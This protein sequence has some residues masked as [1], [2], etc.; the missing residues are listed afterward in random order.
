MLLALAI[1]APARADLWEESLPMGPGGLVEVE[2]DLGEGL[3]PDPGSLTIRSHSRDEVRMEI[4]SGGWGTWGLAPRLVE[5]AGRVRAEARVTGATTWMFG[6]PNVRVRLWV[7]EKTSLEVRAKG[8]PVRIEELVGSVRARVR[9]GDLEIRSIEGDVKLRLHQANV[10]VEEIHGG[11]DV[12]STDGDIHAAWV[13][14]D[15]E[16]RSSDGAIRLE[17]LRGRALAKTLS[18]DV[19]VTQVSGP[20]EARTESGQLRVSFVGAP[21]G[22]LLVERGNVEVQVPAGAG[23]HLDAEVT[24]GELELAPNLLDGSGVSPTAA[25]GKVGAGGGLLVLR[26]SRGWIRVNGR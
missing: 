21:E 23:F 10:D 3:R 17:H 12:K 1:A 13:S 15:V 11:L 14:G 7:P 25:H 5:S 26:S 6:G 9:D 24:R 8:G 20:V 16:A 18:G 22:S 19:E 4:E 2:F